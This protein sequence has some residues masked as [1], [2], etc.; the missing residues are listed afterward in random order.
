[1]KYIVIICSIIGVAM[2][3][4]NTSTPQ[5]NTDTSMVLENKDIV[6][7]VKEN[8]LTR[9]KEALKNGADS[10]A[11][12]TNQQSLLLLATQNNNLEMASLLVSNKADV[13]QQSNNL[14]S[15]FLYAGANGLT[16]F[17]KLY[18]ANGARFDVYNRYNGTALIPA[19]ERG[20]VETVRVLATTPN[21]PLNHINRLGWTGL[22]ESILLGDGSKKYQE[23]IKILKDAGAKTDI[24]DKDGIT[25]L[26]HAQKRGFTEIVK[27]LKS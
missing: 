13:N 10:N 14:D 3:C 18:L 15:P 6:K 9:V 1:M 7:Y 27:I 5:R 22:I 21:F 11:T 19:C 26:E 24:P 23:I 12:D 25:P 20:H 16:D 4:S 8:N 17:I 2:S